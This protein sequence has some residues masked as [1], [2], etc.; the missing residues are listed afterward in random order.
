MKR[1]SIR[2]VIA[3]F[4]ASVTAGCVTTESITATT[5]LQRETA[6]YI[7]KHYEGVVS[8][9]LVQIS[10]VRK[11]WTE[12]RWKAETL[13][14]KYDCSADDMFRSVSCIVGE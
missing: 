10:D 5:E 8:P 6:S 1:F 4:A 14:S 11:V 9:E 2:C 3:L 13:Q 12:V 7:K